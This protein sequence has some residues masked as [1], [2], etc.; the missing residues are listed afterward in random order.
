MFWRPH[1][2][3]NK[4][5]AKRLHL[6]SEFPKVVR[7]FLNIGQRPLLESIRAVMM[8][9]VI[10]WNKSSCGRVA[11][12]ALLYDLTVGQFVSLGSL[13]SQSFSEFCPFR[14]NLGMI[15]VGHQQRGLGYVN[16]YLIAVYCREGCGGRSAIPGF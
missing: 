3:G 1:W 8:V 9:G 4:V 2:L 10:K 15:F 16:L 5:D 14:F 12:N 13:V 6:F 11:A 7:H